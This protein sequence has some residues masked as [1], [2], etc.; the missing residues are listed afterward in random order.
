MTYTAYYR[1]LDATSI[2]IG[3]DLQKL[4]DEWCFGM[5]IFETPGLTSHQLQKIFPDK[6]GMG[7]ILNWLRENYKEVYKDG[8]I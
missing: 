4:K 8:P 7:T 6:P 1:T 5:A 3:E 2:K